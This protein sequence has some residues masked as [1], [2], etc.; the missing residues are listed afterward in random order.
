MYILVLAEN[1][2]SSAFISRGLKFENILSETKSIHEDFINAF[3]FNHYDCV[4]C[5]MPNS[6]NITKKIL[7]KINT[8][9]L[10]IP[11]FILLNREL[12]HLLDDYNLPTK[13]LYPTNIP[14]RFL[15]YEIKK[16][17]NKKNKN[18]DR[19]LEVCDI[20]L[21]LNRREV[22]RFDKK[23]YLRNKEFQLLEYLMRNKDILLSRQRILENVWDRNAHLMTNTVDVHINSLRKK[24]DYKKN[25]LLIETIYCNGYIFHSKPF[26]ATRQLLKHK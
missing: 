14:T 2:L 13:H 8:L 18:K 11:L 3:M 9:K 19:M 1:Q 15:A 26:V 7:N 4:I 23:H 20:K 10:E 12:F 17:L 25:Y 6:I 5:K 24:I 22:H 16:I 21:N